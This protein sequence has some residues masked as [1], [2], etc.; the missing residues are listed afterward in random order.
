MSTVSTIQT[1]G[2][3]RPVGVAVQ[4]PLI[5]A[6]YFAGN[7]K[8]LDALGKEGEAAA[9]ARLVTVLKGFDGLSRLDWVPLSSDV[10]M[11]RVIFEIGGLRGLRAVNKRSSL[12]AIEGPLVRPFVNAAVALIGPTPKGLLKFLPKAW[13]ASTRGLGTIEMTGLGDGAGT[14]VFED[15]PRQLLGDVPWLEGFCGVIEGIYETTRHTGT[16]PS[17]RVQD[18]RVYYDVSWKKL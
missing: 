11:T 17:P 12:M 5:K 3:P 16:A 9:R 8:A 1:R 10:E 14:I 7:I 15:L 13:Q 6:S 4:D 18:G 2:A